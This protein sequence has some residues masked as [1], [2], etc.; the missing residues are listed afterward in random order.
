MQNVGI[1]FT[2]LLNL[3]Y[4]H[5]SEFVIQTRGNFFSNKETG[6]LISLK[7]DG[8]K[9][10]VNHIFTVLLILHDKAA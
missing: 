6:F 5:I 2:S 1:L 4:I 9:F 8:A 7:S 10:K 3:L